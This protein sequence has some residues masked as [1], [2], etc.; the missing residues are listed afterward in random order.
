MNSVPSL[1]VHGKADSS[2]PQTHAESAHAALESSEL[3]LVDEASNML[4][5]GQE[6]ETVSRRV[7]AFL[8]GIMER[9]QVN[10]MHHYHPLNTKN[11]CHSSKTNKRKQG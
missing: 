6:G 4:W 7:I 5:L 1:V 2:V 10:E 9:G 8:M 3:Y 11:E